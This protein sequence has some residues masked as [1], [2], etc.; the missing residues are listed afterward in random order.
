MYCLK[1][2]LKHILRRH[3]ASPIQA[4]EE[5]TSLIGKKQSE[6]ESGQPIEETSFGGT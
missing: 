6:S 2:K 3:H 1:K 4:T 5:T